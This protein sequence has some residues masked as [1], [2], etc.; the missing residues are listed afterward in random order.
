MNC[1]KYQE[2]LGDLVDGI[3]SADDRALVETHVDGCAACAEVRDDFVA[4]LGFCRDHRGEYD[5]VP[6]E[7]ALWLRISNIIAAE[8][9]RA[10]IVDVPSGAGWWSR[11]MNKSWQL[12]LPKLAGSAAAIVVV[13]FLATVFT[14]GRLSRS[15]PGIAR[16][17]PTYSAPPEDRYR[18]Q[19][20]AIAY[21][22]QRVEMNKARWNAQMRET[23]D[24]NMGVIDSAVNDSMIQLRQNPHDTVS[25]D[26]L[27]DALN[28]KVALLKEFAE[29]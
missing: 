26:I 4:I 29:L 18:Q 5:A 8:S 11:L 12:S 28:D 6:N 2:L 20:Q 10:R 15:G 14:T 1:E 25:E 22:N 27:N 23:F 3:A 7:R 21:W 17:V 19:Q 9:P 13:V 24:R 16:E